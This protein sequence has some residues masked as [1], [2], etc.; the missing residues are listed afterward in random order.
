MLSGCGK[1]Y[2]ENR[3]LT[4]SIKVYT[5]F[6]NEIENVDS[7]ESVIKAYKKVVIFHEKNSSSIREFRSTLLANNYS[8]E[9]PQELQDLIKKSKEISYKF[10]TATIKLMGYMENEKLK[11]LVR[12][13][14]E[15]VHKRP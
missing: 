15:A 4:E 3:Y 12:R 14:F 6:T 11:E 9:Y 13:D 2:K 1:Y 5:N 8:G 10:N 7:E